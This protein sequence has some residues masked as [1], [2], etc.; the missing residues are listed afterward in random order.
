M[1]SFRERVVLRA[2]VKSALRRKGL[3]FEKNLTKRD[4]G[5][6]VKELNEENQLVQPITVAEVSE[7]YLEIM[8][9]LVAEH[10]MMMKAKAQ[11]SK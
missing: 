1:D 10:F 5:R 9:E 4:M 3:M 7:L 11:S 6:E 8:G 2:I